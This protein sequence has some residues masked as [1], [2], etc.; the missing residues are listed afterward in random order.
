MSMEWQLQEA[1]NR[2]SQLIKEIAHDGPQIITVRGKPAAVLLSVEEY[3]RLTSPRTKLTDFFRESPLC[4]EELDLE[5]S[6][7]LAREVEL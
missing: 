2:L 4:S 3:Q 1:K 7:D 6:S 5:R